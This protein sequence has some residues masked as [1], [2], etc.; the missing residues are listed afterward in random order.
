MRC[1][2]GAATGVRGARIPG[3]CTGPIG[4]DDV[5]VHVGDLVQR[6]L[7]G[8]PLPLPL[9]ALSHPLERVR[10]PPRVV[11]ALAVAGSLLAAARIEVGDAGIDLLVGAGL[12]LAP[13]DP[14]LDVDVP[15]AVALVPAVHEVGALG[16]LVP[17]AT[18]RD[19]GLRSP[20]IGR[21]LR[22]GGLRRRRLSSPSTQSKLAHGQR[23]GCRCPSGTSA[24]RSPRAMV[25]SS[26]SSRQRGRILGEV[27][28]DVL[29]PAV[30]D[31]GVQEL[32]S[33]HLA[34]S[35]RSP[36]AAWRE[37]HRRDRRRA[38]G[39]TRSGFGAR[40]RRSG[41]PRR[42]G[43]AR[44]V[45]RRRRWGRSRT[46]RAAATP[47]CIG[48]PVRGSAHRRRRGSPRSACDPGTA[49]RMRAPRPSRGAGSRRCTSG[50]CPRA[51]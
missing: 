6:L 25:P 23:P 34:A 18:S 47:P 49:V 22:R 45:A 13:D 26:G 29:R 3:D 5:D 37:L 33:S 9:A 8:D 44:A 46:R 21:R 38:D 50:W 4:G 42:G 11:H 48:G 1:D 51:G 14:V 7:P 39:G 43:V 19:R 41:P 15:A 35:W 36:P 27:G 32:R 17:A 30:D 24:G 12:L 40:S 2:G 31:Q 16:D 20:R 10:E 28:E